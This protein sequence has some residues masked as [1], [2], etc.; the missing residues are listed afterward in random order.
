[1]SGDATWEVWKLLRKTRLSPSAKLV[2]LAMGD[3]AAPDGRGWT[4]AENLAVITG[5]SPRAVQ[6]ARR[7]LA[8][9]RVIVPHVGIRIR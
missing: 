7:E 5:L 9:A 6:R 8:L 3:I 1:M 4:T 2:L